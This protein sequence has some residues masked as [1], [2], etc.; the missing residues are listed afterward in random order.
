MFA[1]KTI[2]EGGS[3][4]PLLID[5]APTEGTGTTNPSIYADGKKLLFNV[6]H[7]EYSLYHSEKKI[8]CHPWGPLQYLHR[9]ND[10]HL[11]TN[12]YFGNLKED[13]SLDT[14]TKVDTS[15]FDKAPLWEFVGLE[16]VRIV[17][18]DK[19]L[20]ISGVRR[21]TTPNGQGRMELSE[22]VYE[23]GQYK[24]V[25]RFRIPAPESDN[26]Y[27]EKNWMPILDMPFHYVKWCNPT[28]VVKVDI[29]NETSE[30]VFLG[31][32]TEPFGYDF[33]GGSQVLTYGDY[34]FC[35]VH[36]FLPQKSETGRKDGMYKHAFIVWDK[37]WNVVKYGEPFSFLE[38]KIEFS[39]GACFWK[40]DLLITFGFQDNSAFLLRVKEKTYKKMILPTKKIIVDCFSYFDPINKE[41]LELRINMLKDYVDKFV[42]CEA[43]T[44]HSGIPNKFNLK[45]TIKK[46]NLPKDKIIIIE[47]EIPDE[48]SLIP[49]EMDYINCY[50]GNNENINSVK[51]RARERLQRDSL[52][53]VLDQFDEGATFIVSDCDEII[54]PKNINF[55]SEWAVKYK[56]LLIKVP[57][58]HLEGKADLRVYDK[59]TNQPK[60]WDKSMFICTKE[61]LLKATPTQMRSAVNLPFQ[62][63]YIT[64][65]GAPIQDLGW[66]FSWMGDKTKR[67]IKR[68]SFI[69]FNDKL[70]YLGNTTYTDKK[71]AELVEAK[72]INEGSMPPSGDL[73]CIL[74][75]YD[76]NNLP[77]EIFKTKT[78]NNFF[79]TQ[80]KLPEI[81]FHKIDEQKYKQLGSEI[82]ED[83][84]KNY[85]YAQPGQEHYR[86]LSSLSLN[87]K[88][89]TILDI[90]TYKGN[91]ALAL[92]YNNTNNVISFDIEKDTTCLNNKSKNISFIVDNILQEK[93]VQNIL[94]TPLIVLDTNHD[95]TFEKIFF[96]HLVQIKY[97]GLVILDDIKL[98]EPMQTFWQNITQLKYD[99]TQL[100]HYTGTGLVVF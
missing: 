59:T 33:R 61:H 58:V 16:D 63:T 66:H 27:C 80:N 62:I 99:V 76:L 14:Y 40:N 29:E 5:S 50:E 23:D 96:E 11:R 64:Q 75:K 46:L 42:I 43:N 87:Y 48:E 55:L 3:I 37:D 68:E 97:K 83:E 31:K 84:F 53:D 13:F 77:K 30:T 65:D 22:I 35:I 49:T 70:S 95:G 91:S 8:Y 2:E 47:K 38:G 32:T 88:N 6:R 20:Y 10:M 25:S 4:H 85:F 7:V 52:L 56:Q 44:T 82:I 18:W 9:E 89:K 92:S 19:K 60:L 100:G 73:S 90:G 45:N 34:R 21:D 86:L 1:K 93:Y 54:D 36:I 39:C 71:I 74:K 12:N 41:L 67:K 72:T 98:N 78:T 26:S 51:A 94:N 17:R 57:L 69:H 81:N 15:T 28:Q 24:E 79:L